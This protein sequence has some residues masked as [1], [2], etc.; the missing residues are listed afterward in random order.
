MKNSRTRNPP[1]PNP[2]LGSLPVVAGAMHGPVLAQAR[3]EA[4]RRL[5]KDMGQVA[6]GWGGGLMAPPHPRRRAR[7]R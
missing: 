3:R 5:G 4:D 1:W 2:R 7:R 6:G